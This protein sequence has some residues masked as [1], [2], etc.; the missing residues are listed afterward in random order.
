MG[1]AL[2]VTERY[3]YYL[4]QSNKLKLKYKTEHQLTAAIV[5]RSKTL[6]QYFQAFT[7][8]YLFWH[9]SV[10]IDKDASAYKKKILTSKSTN[11]DSIL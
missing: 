11:N 1:K 8:P 10:K 6:Q 9:S 4:L 5:R 2:Q 7:F 3:T